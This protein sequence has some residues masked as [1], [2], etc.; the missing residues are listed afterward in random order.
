MKLISL[1]TVGL[2][3]ELMLGSPER[4]SWTGLREGQSIDG[5]TRKDNHIYCG[6]VGCG[7]KPMVGVDVVSF[8]VCPGSKYTKDSLHVYYPISIDCIDYATCGVCACSKYVISNLVV[9]DFNYLGKDYATDKV[10]VFFRGQE[11]LGADGK[12]FRVIDGPEFFY[13]AVDKNKVYKHNQVFPGADPAT[14]YYDQSDK[15]N[16]EAWNH[17]NIADKRH[18]WLFVPPDKIKMIK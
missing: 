8:K 15:R 14:F 13:F 16:D 9:K 7:A 6:E 18:R 11:L 2:V 1:C 3:F 12:S 4:K 17:Y 5:Y 10:K